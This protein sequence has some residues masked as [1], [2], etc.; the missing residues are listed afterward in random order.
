MADPV[1]MMLVGS[2]VGAGAQAAGAVGTY[3]Q[4]KGDAKNLD[5]RANQTLAETGA[6]EQAQRRQSTQALANMQA[7]QAQSGVVGGSTA[8]VYRQSAIDAELDALNIRYEGYSRASAL[9]QQARA[10]KKAAT[11]SAIL[12]L[13]SAG[14]TAVGGVGEAKA[15]QSRMKVQ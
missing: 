1:T 14:A 2:A 9:K 5:A 6:A 13:V 11:A 12:G 4:G 8:D 15:Y 3:F 7:A 10:T